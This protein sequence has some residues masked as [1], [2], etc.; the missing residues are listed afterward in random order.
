VSGIESVVKALAVAYG[1]PDAALQRLLSGTATVNYTGRAGGRQIFV[2]VYQ[3]ST[4]LNAERAAIELSQFAAAGGVPTPAVIRSLDGSLIHRS[5]QTR[6]SVWE[7]V[8]GEPAG[9]YGLTERQMAA[10]GRSLGRLHRVL[11]EHPAAP[12]TV[13]PASALCDVNRSIGKIDKVLAALSH[14][15]DADEFQ[16]W[17]VD[18]LRWRLALMPR[19]TEILAGLPP[20]TCQILHGDFA[21][22]NVLLHHD[23]VA[24][25]IDFRPPRAR[26]VAWEISRVGCDPRT[27]LRGEQWQRGLRHLAAGY[28]EEHNDARPDD[29]IAMVRAWVCY[30]ATSIYP[31]DE[32][33]T[34]ESLLA[35]PLK[36]YARDR[37]QALVVAMN[38]LAK[39]EDALR[40]TLG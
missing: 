17:A 24:A 12:C 26:P 6:F 29:L 37:Q 15:P 8:R 23:R 10:V 1:W 32:L 40:A 28:R 18:V 36:T 27:V 16:A 34:G 22:P 38:D 3:P 30:S 35:G 20:L 13:E 39:V 2:K 25:V 21:A 33:V 14:K 4:D 11:A 9:E 19:I 31:F 7:F 5:D